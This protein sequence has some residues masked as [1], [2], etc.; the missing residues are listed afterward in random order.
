MSEKQ[1]DNYFLYVSNH[2]LSSGIGLMSRFFTNGLGDWGSI[3]G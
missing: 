2:F 1:V 3:P